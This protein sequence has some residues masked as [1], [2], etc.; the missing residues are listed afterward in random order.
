MRGWLM[1]LAYGIGFHKPIAATNRRLASPARASSPPGDQGGI[2]ESLMEG[3]LDTIG[4]KL[5]VRTPQSRSD[6]VCWRYF[7]DGA[8]S[9]SRRLRAPGIPP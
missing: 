8:P 4:K 5:R 6:V 9:P 3:V 2:I 1:P 7:P